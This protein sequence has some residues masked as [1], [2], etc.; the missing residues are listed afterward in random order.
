MNQVTGQQKKRKAAIGTAAAA[1]IEAVT[2]AGIGVP[3]VTR[4][5]PSRRNHNNQGNPVKNH[6]QTHQAVSAQKA[7]AVAVVA[8]G[9][10][11][12]VKT[13]V[14]EEAA[15][16]VEATRQVVEPRRVENKIEQSAQGVAQC[17][18]IAPFQGYNFIKP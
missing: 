18:N 2:V 8:T 4:L 10:A 1:G 3:V 17:C 7:A 16:V 15:A 11:V 14:A 5:K 12:V 9:A 13:A 6:L